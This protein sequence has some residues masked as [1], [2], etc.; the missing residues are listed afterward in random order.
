V[1]ARL[2]VGIGN[3][4]P[5]YA[6]TRHNAGFDVVDL[7]ASNLGVAFV[8]DGAGGAIARGIVAGVPFWLS[9]PGT[10]VNRTGDAIAR[11]R[12]SADLDPAGILIVLDDLALE[13]GRLRFRAAGSHGGHNGLRSVIAEL[14]TEEVPRLRV[15]IGS[16]PPDRWR[17][18]VLSP[19]RP[20]ELDVIE[21]AYARA[22]RA[23]VD[24]L[25]GKG[26][27]AIAADINRAS[28]VDPIRG[29]GGTGIRGERHAG[30][31]GRGAREDFIPQGRSSVA[32]YEGMFLLDNSRV[33]PEAAESTG[34]VTE[35]LKKHGA[36]VV[37]IDR[38]DERKLAYEVKKQKRGT[39]V[40]SHFEADPAVMPELRHDVN[41]NESVL[42]A[43]ILRVDEDFPA[44][45][46]AAEYEALRPKREDDDRGEEGG[47][48][49]EGDRGRRSN[50]DEE[51]LDEIV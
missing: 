39:F 24:F 11:L 26:A 12:Q 14:G 48:R 42:R 36:E 23:V 50:R 1:A 6:G 7:A 30:P 32:K 34:A 37:K 25:S 22:A 2:V 40:L 49:Y 4:G 41:L 31:P 21:R 38:W 17:E 45:M 29:T 18:H 16:A 28:P 15:G 46:S 10:F 20:E 51:P 43:L 19:F 47:R 13:P 5:E 8:P 3:P 9:K 35:L 33:K 27:D 44:W